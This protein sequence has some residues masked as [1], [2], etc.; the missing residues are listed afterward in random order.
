MVMN[1]RAAQSEPK[2]LIKRWAVAN[3]QGAIT[4]Q[5]TSPFFYACKRCAEKALEDAKRLNKK[6]GGIFGTYETYLGEKVIRVGIVMPS[7]ENREAAKKA[8]AA[9]DKPKILNTMW[10]IVNRQGA[11]VED[12]NCLLICAQRE[13]AE[14]SC[15][16]DEKVIRVEIVKL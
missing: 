11:I 14:Y 13:W 9:K 3:K 10:A 5:D 12:D 8:M 1:D 15:G 16:P 4:W 6:A 7:A 2:R